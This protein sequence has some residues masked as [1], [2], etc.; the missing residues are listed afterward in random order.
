M[1]LALTFAL[2]VLHFMVVT[3]TH[4]AV[5]P[6]IKRCKLN[7]TQATDSEAGTLT[8]CNP[9]SAG[10]LYQHRRANWQWRLG[11][12]FLNQLWERRDKG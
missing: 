4:A 10:T 8:E 3:V 9:Y 11:R 5:V 2:T 12:S 6:S 1:K 7:S